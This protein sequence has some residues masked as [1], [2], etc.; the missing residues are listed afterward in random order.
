MLKRAI[1]LGFAGFLCL[2][3]CT[4]A[5]SQNRV[6]GTV[7]DGDSGETL[8]GA[9]ILV[10]GTV[11]GTITDLDGT[12]ELKVNQ[13][14]PFTLVYSLLGYGSQTVEITSADQVVDIVMTQESV[15][16]DEVVVSA[17]RV[18]ESIL[19][20]PVS[21]EKIGL[22]ELK[23]TA[24][25]DF[26]DEINNMKGVIR[27]QASLTFNTIN[28]RGFATGGNTRFVQ[29]QDGMDNAAP[30]LNFPTGNVVG[31][32]ELDIKTIELVPGAASAL[33]GP[34]AFNGIL[35]MNSKDPWNY[36]GLSAQLKTGVTQGD[37]T[38]PLYGASIRWADQINDKF[39][40]K[41]NIS[42]LFAT[43]W[44]A[45]DYTNHI[46]DYRNEAGSNIEPGQ[47]RFSGVNLYG[48]ETPIPLT[49]PDGST[50]VLYRNGYT[51]Q[52]LL[53]NNDA[54]S[55]KVDGALH[56]RLTDNL[57][58]S[59]SYKWGSGS[60]VYQG[61]ERYAL[62]NFVQQFA[63]FELKASNWN[64]NAYGSFTDDGDSYNMSAL[65]AIANETIWPSL[66]SANG[67][68]AG[69][70]VAANIAYGGNLDLFGIE[71]G[72]LDVAKA[73]ANGGGFASLTEAARQAFA[74]GFDA[75]NPNL[76]AGTGTLLVQNA[77][78]PS[79]NDLSEQEL[80]A[81]VEQVRSGLFQS[82]GA[83][84]I[85]NSKMYHV[86]GNYDF[87]EQINNVIGLQAGANVRRYSLFTEGTVF[88][89]Y[90]SET[91]QNE[92]ININE[93]G[94]Y[95]QASK[96]LFD[97]LKI[98][99]SLRYDKNQN[100]DGQISPR[101]SAVYSIDDNKRHNIRASWQTGFRNP[102]TQGQYIFFPASQ[103]LL[104]GTKEN[105]DIINELD[106]SI[107]NIF[108]DGALSADGSTMVDLE[109]VKPER[110]TSFEVG[111]KGVIGSNMFLDINY[112]RNTYEDFINQLSVLST[113]D[114]Q[115]R[116]TIYP[117]GGR[118]FPYTNVP[119]TFN[120]DGLDLGF[121]YKLNKN[122][123]VNGN[124]SRA[125][126]DFDSAEL[127]GT[128]FEG[129]NFDPG[130]NTPENKFALGLTSKK[131]FGN[132]GFGMNYRW[133]EEFF[134]SSSFGNGTIP[135]FQTLD[136]SISYK[137]PSM[138]TLAKLGITNLLK[139]DYVTNVGNPTIGRMIVLTLTYDQF[140]N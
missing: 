95:V 42:T 37:E 53:D 96:E 133:Q 20:S 108:E 12:Y 50:G 85:D 38:N 129:S 120:S 55:I 99:G 11:T 130:F 77:S 86:E 76:P 31:I 102:T 61:S 125:T 74:A 98:S 15:L 17:S 63:K 64:I 106:G 43:D 39:A 139:E 83:G 24:A 26:Y 18:E 54:T 136:A 6:T 128:S 109:Y 44:Q 121:R 110:L 8:I 118:W 88:R 137:I 92:R 36:Q 58:A 28:T 45:T 90:N 70:A 101:V 79:S 103:V 35:F 60:S 3:F 7:T 134:Y 30:L 115:Y 68:P 127:V 112:Y 119:I 72:N 23:A 5:I 124:Y 71:G 132:F 100:F 47:A 82:G 56:Y 78:G 87:S 114:V 34:N 84:F 138:K 33:Y 73:F 69:W 93:W 131:I 97:A 116:G 81:I 29:L 4:N 135:S 113:K 65:G 48:D 104:G 46:F 52:F 32:S 89:E 111:Y 25:G 67:L 57:E 9:N 62:R 107:F 19:Q 94:G 59:A 13:D 126:V 140:S 21:V 14:L 75:A 51:E 80:L 41:F 66:T 49:G 16:A 27:T 10:K 1:N 40:Y 22:Q 122:W 2:F 105:A 123:A 91:D 117:A